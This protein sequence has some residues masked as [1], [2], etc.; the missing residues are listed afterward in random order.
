MSQYISSYTSSK[1]REYVA[2]GKLVGSQNEI[3]KKKNKISPR[4]TEDRQEKKRK[5]RI[6]TF[7]N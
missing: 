4:T 6:H 1:L 3:I 7:Q 2:R 5:M